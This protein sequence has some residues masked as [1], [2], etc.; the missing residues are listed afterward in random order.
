MQVTQ[1]R[2]SFKTDHK[3]NLLFPAFLSIYDF[4]LWDHKD[5]LLARECAKHPLVKKTKVYFD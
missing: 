5:F 4:E 1:K 2:V 3:E